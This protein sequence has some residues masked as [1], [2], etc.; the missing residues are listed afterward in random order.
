MNETKMRERILFDAIFRFLEGLKLSADKNIE[1]ID[2]GDGE[3]MCECGFSLRTIGNPLDLAMLRNYYRGH[4]EALELI[5]EYL[6]VCI[7]K[8]FDV[9][10]IPKADR[11][12]RVVVDNTKPRANGAE[13]LLVTTKGA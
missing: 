11:D 3:R 5:L 8:K 6:G 12:L 1:V 2:S 10:L 7:T 9:S 4:S 13:N